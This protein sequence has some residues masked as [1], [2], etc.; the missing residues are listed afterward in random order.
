MLRRV[1]LV[2]TDVLEEL[3]TSRI[4]VTRIDELETT[5]NTL[6]LLLVTANVPS[7][8]IN[9]TLVEP[10]LSSRTS[11]LTRVTGRN[12]PED[13]ILMKFLCENEWKNIGF[14]K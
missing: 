5:L 2:R 3:V 13:D 11:I 9:I 8:P 7:S 4:R 6:L 10:I 1:A 12:I 14:L